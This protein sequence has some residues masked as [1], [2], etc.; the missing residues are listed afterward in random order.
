MGKHLHYSL[1][2]KLAAVEMY[3]NQGFSCD[4]IAKQLL[5]RDRK[6][7]MSWVRKFETGGSQ[8]LESQRGLSRCIKKGRP[9]KNVTIENE[10]LRLRAENDYLRK[11]LELQG[12]LKKK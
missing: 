2:Q 6:R 12:V 8:A 4:E 10:I 1:S 11:V 7:V 3:L 9:P 5:V